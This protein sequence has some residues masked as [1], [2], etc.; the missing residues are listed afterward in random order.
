MGLPLATSPHSADISAL[1]GM[2]GY[3]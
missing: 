2:K 3:I 1:Q